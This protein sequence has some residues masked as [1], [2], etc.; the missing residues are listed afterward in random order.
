MKKIKLSFI[1][2]LFVVIL[3]SCESIEKPSNNSKLDKNPS[4]NHENEFNPTFDL[5][6]PDFF[7]KFKNYFDMDKDS[8]REALEEDFSEKPIEGTE[9]N[10]NMQW[11]RLNKSGLQ[12][13]LTEESEV[14]VSHVDIDESSPIHF[15]RAKA[16]MKFEDI[17]KQAGETLILEQ[18]E[19]DQVLYSISYP[20][21]GVSVIF[22]TKNV[23]EE[24]ANMRV[25]SWGYYDEAPTLLHANEIP[26]Y[27][28]ILKIP[29]TWVGRISLIDYPDT[30]I[31]SYL[32]QNESFP[33]F[34]IISMSSEEWDGISKSEQEEFV[35]IEKEEGWIMVMK[36]EN[37]EPND[38][39]ESNEYHAMSSEIEDIIKTFE[40]IAQSV[41]NNEN[42]D[43]NSGA[44]PAD[45]YFAEMILRAYEEN[46]I[47][48]LNNNDFGRIEKY[49][50]DDS[51]FFNQT[52]SMISEQV[53]KGKTY[54]L[55]SYDIEDIVQH[56]DSNEEYDL[57]VKEKIALYDENQNKSIEKTDFWI[58]TIIS[59]EKSEGISKRTVWK[60]TE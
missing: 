60:T 35:T 40:P 18:E 7:S 29:D 45:S 55:I 44:A 26:T 37:A 31:I 41:M 20:V 27:Y 33:L 3:S 59:N 4:T 30:K 14:P 54:T 25:S 2:F 46:V 34:Q 48:A 21:E 11:I 42:N 43:L 13:Y 1:L 5:N 16:K 51:E 10:T 15:G 24:S 57:Y 9:P 52:K 50:I 19:N 17:M 6:N 53:P 8:L 38:E 58:Y 22:N 23:F 28:G 56:E 12:F 36:Q 39:I 49:L 47:D 32:G